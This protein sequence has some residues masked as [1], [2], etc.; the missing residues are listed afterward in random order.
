MAGWR[1]S[2]DFGEQNYVEKRVAE[3]WHVVMPKWLFFCIFNMVL[4]RSTVKSHKT[5]RPVGDFGFD[6]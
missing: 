6:I 5:A 2:G 3:Q 4:L 1:V